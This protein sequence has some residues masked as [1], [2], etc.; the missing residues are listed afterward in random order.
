MYYDYFKM[1]WFIIL[2][3]HVIISLKFAGIAKDKGS[4]YG[5]HFWWCFIFG[6]IGWIMVLSLPDDKHSDRVYYQ[7]KKLR[8]EDQSRH[9]QMMKILLKNSN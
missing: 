6:F 4:S 8:D 5:S 3:I 1:F 2:A 9:E 7:L